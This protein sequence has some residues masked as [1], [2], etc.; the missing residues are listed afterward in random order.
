VRGKA[1]GDSG[2]APVRDARLWATPA[3][4]PGPPTAPSA[5]SGE[6][7]IKL[8]AATVHR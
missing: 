3:P 5:R 6:A 8:R 7:E 2:A 4:G 1:G